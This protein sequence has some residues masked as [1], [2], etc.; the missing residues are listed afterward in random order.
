M[1]DRQSTISGHIS[2]LI[3]GHKVTM[4]YNIVYPPVVKLMYLGIQYRQCRN[5]EQNSKRSQYNER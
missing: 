4:Q 3:F 2:G 1:K 5:I